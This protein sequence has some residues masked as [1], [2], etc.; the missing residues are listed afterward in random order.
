MT[1][2]PLSPA[3]LMALACIFG[4]GSMDACDACDDSSSRSPTNLYMAL[5]ATPDSDASVLDP[6]R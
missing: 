3:G 6:T 1:G 5:Q 2:I 4:I